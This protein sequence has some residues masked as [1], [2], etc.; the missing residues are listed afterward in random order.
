VPRTAYEPSQFPAVLAASC[1]RGRAVLFAFS[2]RLWHRDFFGHAMGLD[3]LFWRAVVWAA[4]KPF[5]AQLMPPYVTLRVDDAIG[6]HDFCYVNVMND[7]G[8]HPLIACFVDEV[9]AD[10]AP[11]MRARS[12]RGQVDWD[13][14]ALDYYR[15]IP[16]NFGVG[17]YDDDRLAQIFARVDAWY[18]EGG[19]QPPRTAYFHWGEIGRNA[20]PY[21]KARGRT[22]VYSPYHLG[23]LKWERIFPNWWPYGLNSLFYDHH[24][25][26]PDLYNVGAS[27]PRHIIEPDV[28]TGCTTWAG[29]NPTNDMAKAA[30]RSAQAVR[31]ALDSGFFAEM[32]THEQKFAVLSL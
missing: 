9:P 6:R 32:T 19:F 26:D 2:P 23:Q 22:F 15:L 20:L 24:P 3:A 29:D 25:E 12:E 1:G 4:R 30:G 31:L 13:A 16:F 7:H 27:L 10:L 21:L 14:H 18:A 5:V 28:L 17:E 8:L 11:F